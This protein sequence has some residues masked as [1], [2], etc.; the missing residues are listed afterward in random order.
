MSPFDPFQMC[1]RDGPTVRAAILECPRLFGETGSPSTTGISHTLLP[2]STF[3][4]I[5]KGQK[6]EVL[7]ENDRCILMIRHSS[8]F[9]DAVNEGANYHEIA[10]PFR[11]R[12]NHTAVSLLTVECLAGGLFIADVGSRH[13]DGTYSDFSAL[14]INAPNPDVIDDLRDYG[15]NCVRARAVARRIRPRCSR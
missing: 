2:S 11:D 12:G 6:P 3:P 15:F 10:D 8:N 4:Q 14:R 9:A 1:G 13:P 7:E 5:R